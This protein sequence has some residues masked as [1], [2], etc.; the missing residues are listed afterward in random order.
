MI[1]GRFGENGELFFEL[2]L[3]PSSGESFTAPVLLDTGFTN[4]WLV[5]NQQDFEALDWSVVLAQS[6]MRTARG[7]GNFYIYEGKV[8]VDEVEVIIPVH[9]GHNVPETAMGSAWLDIME[10]IVNKQ[11]G[12]LTLDFIAAS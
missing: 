11:E 12:I 8:I 7:Q 4:G 6:K 1:Q 9:V 10:L 3:V 2:Q 5:I